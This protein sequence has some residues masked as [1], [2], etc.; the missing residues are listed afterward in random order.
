MFTKDFEIA[1]IVVISLSFA[2]WIDWNLVI[3]RIKS[4]FENKKGD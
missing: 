4:W 2:V 1:F 3:A